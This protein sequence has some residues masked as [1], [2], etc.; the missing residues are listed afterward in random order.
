MIK[1]RPHRVSSQW[2]RFLV[3]GVLMKPLDYVLV[4]V[5]VLAA[6]AEI[7]YLVRRGNCHDCPYQCKDEDDE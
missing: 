1:T 7:I 2:R 5:L 3:G 6:V 4:G